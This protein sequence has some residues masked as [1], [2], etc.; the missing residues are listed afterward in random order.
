MGAVEVDRQRHL[1]ALDVLE[2]QGRPARLDGAVGDL[3]DLKVAAD[4]LRDAT[5]VALFFQE[6]DEISEVA[7]RHG[8]VQFVLR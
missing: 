8:L 2:K 6:V 4:G 3:G 1:V 5:Q 7:K